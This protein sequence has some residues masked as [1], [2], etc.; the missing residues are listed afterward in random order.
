MVKLFMD[1]FTWLPTP[2]Y[3]LVAAVCFIFVII[4]F[5]QVLKLIYDIVGMLVNVFAGAFTKISSL[6]F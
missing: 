3:L 5:C 1:C 2:M 6:F 4:V